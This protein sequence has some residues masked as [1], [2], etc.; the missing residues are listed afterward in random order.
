VIGVGMEPI[1]KIKPRESIK[2]N[3]NG[4]NKDGFS[5]LLN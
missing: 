1:Q 5:Y 4:E 3:K 2:T